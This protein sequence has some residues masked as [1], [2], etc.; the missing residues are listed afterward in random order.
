MTLVNLVSCMRSIQCTFLS[1]ALVSLQS[2]ARTLVRS[3]CPATPSPLKC[4]CSPGRYSWQN[5]KKELDGFFGARGSAS[6]FFFLEPPVEPFFGFPPP[7]TAAAL[8]VL[9]CFRA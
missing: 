5:Q 2:L 1:S 9:F 8:V 7:D 4:S 3:C 6:D